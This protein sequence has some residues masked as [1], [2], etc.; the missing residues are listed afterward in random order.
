MLN[1]IMWGQEAYVVEDRDKVT[2]LNTS[3]N[4]KRQHIWQK[5]KKECTHS[6]MKSHQITRG[7]GNYPEFG[8]VV[9]I[10]DEEKNG[11]EWKI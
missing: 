8:E 1:K 7:D 6:L 10:V 3:L 9:V 4:E 2:K 5:W 11:G